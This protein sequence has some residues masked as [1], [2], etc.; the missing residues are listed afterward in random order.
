MLAQIVTVLI[1][2][3]VVSPIRLQAQDPTSLEEENG[4]VVAWGDIG[5]SFGLPKT[6]AIVT[7]GGVTAATPKRDV[8]LAP[9]AGVGIR[10][11]RHFVPFFA[12]MFYDTGSATATVGSTTANITSTS[13]GYHGGLR[14]ET[15][16]ASNF[17]PYAEGG[18]GGTYQKLGGTTQISGTG[19][20]VLA[21]GGIRLFWGSNSRWGNDFGA[22]WFHIFGNNFTVSNFAHVRAGIFFQSRRSTPARPRVVQVPLPPTQSPQ[23]QEQGTPGTG[24]PGQT[25]GNAGRGESGAIIALGGAGYS[26]GT[27]NV[28]A[29]VVTATGSIVSPGSKSVAAPMVGVGVKLGSH[30]VPFFNLN[31]YDTG[32]A[33]ATNG[34]LTAT[35]D[36]TTIS[37]GGGLRVETNGPSFRPYAEGGAGAMYQKIEGTFVSGGTVVPQNQ[38]GTGPYLM[39]GGGGR[40]FW[41]E[42]TRWGSDFGVDWYHLTGNTF[43]I[44]NFVHVRVGIFFQSKRAK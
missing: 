13:L 44:S 20:T 4:A 39:A 11:K 7:V 19:A 33:S 26:Y 22:D 42:S 3:Y 38:S 28:Q 27:P 30:L 1:M 32:S 2:G 16:V 10:I 8:L 40:L 37:Y 34:T 24:L 25:P 29:S 23:S 18:F 35:V 14:V 17:R 36:S 31:L 43:T 21:G 41:G 12:F 9:T 6:Q 5:W 15:Q